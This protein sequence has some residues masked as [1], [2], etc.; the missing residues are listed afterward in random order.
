MIAHIFANGPYQEE[1]GP[2]ILSEKEG[3]LIIA[4]DGGANKCQLLHI[5]PH[6][7]IGDLDSI[8][9][10]LIEKYSAAGI[11]I[12]QYPTRKDATDLELAIDL[13]MTRGAE[14]IVL[15]GVLGGRWDMS[16]S[17]IML[18]ASKKYNS[19]VIS[20]LNVQCRIHI[21]HG[22]TTLQLKG[23]TGQ[24]TSLIAISADTEGVTISGFEYPLENAIL[25]FGSSIGVSNLL[26]ETDGS[27]TLKHGTLLCIQELATS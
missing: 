10:T 12:I 21:I 27:I 22:K 1:I 23:Y 4:A 16:L 7:I 3:D 8:S 9:P 24:I 18:A 5:D 26:K 11:E 20:L 14:E 2:I 17:N 6:I 13:A 15:F 19:M 25:P